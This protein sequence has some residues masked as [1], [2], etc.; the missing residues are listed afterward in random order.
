MS[1]VFEHIRQAKY[2]L[3]QLLE[4]GFL[5][6]RGFE[7]ELSECQESAKI[8]GLSTA[9]NLLK[10]L[11]QSLTAMRGGQDLFTEASSIY[12]ALTAYYNYITSKLILELI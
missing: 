8:L 6:G 9:H 2:L 11:S 7:T 10:R 4:S 3:Q 12:S 1:P 5:S